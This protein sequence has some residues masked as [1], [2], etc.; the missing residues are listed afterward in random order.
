MS[1][2]TLLVTN[3]NTG[4]KREAVTDGVGTSTWPTC[5]RPPTA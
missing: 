4:F 3:N 2:A 1:G 5:L